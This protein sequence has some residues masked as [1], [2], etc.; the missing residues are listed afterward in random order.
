MHRLPH[1]EKNYIKRDT[2]ILL[3]ADLPFFYRNYKITDA[4]VLLKVNWAKLEILKFNNNQI[5]NINDLKQFNF[6]ELKFLDL[7]NNKISDIKVLEKVKFKKLEKL[8]LRRNEIDLT[9]NN[10]II[11][12]LRP[13]LEEFMI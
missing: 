4:K 7:N 11:S 8:D 13:L 12:K 9:Q 1:L 3:G 5:T 6:N 10:L 2:F